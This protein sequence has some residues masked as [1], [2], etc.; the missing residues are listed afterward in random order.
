MT[1][2]VMCTCTYNN[3]RRRADCTCTRTDYECDFGFQLNPKKECE[4]VPDMP[5]SGF[6]VPED[7]DGFFTV[8][9]GYRKVPGDS[10]SMR[11]A[12]LELYVICRCTDRYSLALYLACFR[13]SDPR[14]SSGRMY[15][16]HKCFC[17]I[18][19]LHI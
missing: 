19:T 18:E 5:L 16:A 14:E 9:R 11:K 6:G 17:A 2:I 7:C 15:P 12:V 13:Q 3:I 8:T 10:V 4:R 1:V